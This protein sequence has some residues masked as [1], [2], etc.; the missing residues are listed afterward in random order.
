MRFLLEKLSLELLPLL[1]LRTSRLQTGQ[2]WEPTE[3]PDPTFP[4]ELHLELS[5]QTVLGLVDLSDP[6]HSPVSP[7][8]V[9]VI[10]QDSER[11]GFQ[12]RRRL[13]HNGPLSGLIPP[14]LAWA[15]WR[16]T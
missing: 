13:S 5:T 1:H 8:T 16:V 11:P 7:T 14:E 3:V 15:S 10:H 4:A 12:Q 6:P 9:T 2:E